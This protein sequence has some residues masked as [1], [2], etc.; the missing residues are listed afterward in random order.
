MSDLKR[1]PLFEFHRSHGARMVP[2]GGWE[3]PVQYTSILAEHR[4]VRDNAGL[5]DVCHMG[6]ILVEGPQA[7]SF[8]D[9]LLTNRV[10]GLTEGKALYAMMCT[11]E[12]GVVD[13][14]ILYRL[15]PNRFFLCINAGNNDSD[16]E[17]IQAHQGRFDCTVAPLSAAYGLL[18]LQGPN[19]QRILERLTPE[20]SK[21]KRF[22]CRDTAIGDIEVLLSRTGYTGE[23]GFEIYCQTA[24]AAELAGNIVS[25]G[26]PDGLAL[27]GLGARD[28]LRLEAGLPLYGHEID[29]EIS[30]LQ[31][32]FDAVVKLDKEAD[33]IGKSALAAEA[34][35][36][37]RR[38]IIFFRLPDRRIARTGTPVLQQGKAVGIVRSGAFSP[39]LER[40]I[41][42]AL[43]DA[44]ALE[45]DLPLC[46][47]LRG[48]Q[49]SLECAAPPLHKT[50]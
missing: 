32:G 28:S 42:S 44:A 50:A 10:T 43:V 21:L 47:D 39:I 8:L 14:L 19:A 33:F 25:A 24:R 37:V 1:T 45:T 40:A 12:G 5:F 22:R 17:W 48:K 23:D 13:D 11:E 2:F 18:A 31:A 9:Y 41:G 26:E 15:G 36:G 35:Q 16:I 6:E 27:C 49:I 38:R 29:T 34:A 20:A 7:E 3:M 4:A 30:P 46:V